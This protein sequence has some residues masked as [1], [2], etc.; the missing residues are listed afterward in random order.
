MTTIS[1]CGLCRKNTHVYPY[2]K[3]DLCTRCKSKLER[4]E[5]R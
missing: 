1:L 5:V 3:L 4:A 2:Y